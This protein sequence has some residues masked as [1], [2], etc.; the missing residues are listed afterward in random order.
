MCTFLSQLPKRSKS[1]GTDQKK[2]LVL[3]MKPCPT[4]KD[5]KMTWYRVRLLAWTTPEKNDRDY[6]FIE[7]YV[8]QVWKKNE[9]G[10]PIIDDEVTCPVTKH[11]H[12]EGNRY[13]A[14]PMCKLAEQYFKALQEANWH[15]ADARTKNKDISRKYQGIIPVYVKDDPNYPKNNG[16]IKVI[17]FGNKKPSKK[18][19]ESG[20]YYKYN[21]YD[22]FKA[23]VEKASQTACVFNGK[24]AVD[25]CFHVAEVSEVRNQGQPNE[26]VYKHKVID[27]I[28]F[29]KP[30][31]A[32]DI[33]SITKELV[34]NS[35]FDDEYYTT[36]TPEELQLFYNRHY[37]ISN[38]DIP[39]EDSMPEYVEK[40]EQKQEVRSSD[41]ENQNAIESNDIS[42]S[43]LDALTNDLASDPDDEG[44]EVKETVSKTSTDVDAT[45]K[46]NATNQ[47]DADV[48]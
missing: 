28:T 23:L 35:G 39:D 4:D 21:Y 40:V 36:S 10:F 7:R 47:N 29:T 25:C 33:P 22:N 45:V 20:E 18:E 41:L 19:L 16:Q 5:G 12:V 31:K 37:K 14:C 48:D 3:S 8:H 34:V 30:E 32:Y 11:V 24:N 9:K 2:S 6:P 38:D 15:N 26:Y 13:D 42:D 46:S 27:K 43:D 44:L 17:I 1:N